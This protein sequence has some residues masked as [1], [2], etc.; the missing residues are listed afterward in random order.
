MSNGCLAFA[1]KVIVE[2]VF[3]ASV[4]LFPCKIIKLIAC[5]VMF[6]LAI[7]PRKQSV[8][9]NISCADGVLL[10]IFSLLPRWSRF[11][12]TENHKVPK[13]RVGMADWILL[14]NDI[15]RSASRPLLQLLSL[16]SVERVDLAIAMETFVGRVCWSVVLFEGRIVN[17]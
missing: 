16:L 2:G 8:T 11:L 10:N 5:H 15:S 6:P 9:S 13:N 17:W 1:R 14:E 3:M 4:R 12:C 7:P